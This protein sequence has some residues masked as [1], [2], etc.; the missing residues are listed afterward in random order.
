MR[1]KVQSISKSF[2]VHQALCIS[3]LTHIIFIGHNDCESQQTQGPSVKANYPPLIMQQLTLKYCHHASLWHDKY[4][5]NALQ[6]NHGSVLGHKYIL[7]TNE[8]WE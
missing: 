6:Y 4:V 5:K 2:R 1:E 3:N 7:Q 8:K